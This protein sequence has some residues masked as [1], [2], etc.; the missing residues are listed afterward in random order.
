M[1]PRTACRAL[2]PVASTS[3][4]AL[5]PRLAPAPRIAFA[6]YSTETKTDTEVDDMY[7][8]PPPP[9]QSNEAIMKRFTGPGFP[10]IPVGVS[11][12]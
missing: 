8:G 7:H 6:R 2:R 3:R 4:P 11:V 1:L 9:K 12:D 10:R 5:A